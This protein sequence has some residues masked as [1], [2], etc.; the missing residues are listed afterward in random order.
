MI[1]AIP[2]T[3]CGLHTYTYLPGGKRAS[4]TTS[5]VCPT[6][7]NIGPRRSSPRSVPTAIKAY[8]PARFRRA[9]AGLSSA[10]AN[11]TGVPNRSE[12]HTSE[13]QSPDHLVCRLLLEK[14]N[15]DIDHVP[16]N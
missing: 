15:R 5:Y 1:P 8:E 16:I 2:S 12:E 9:P 11:S 14:E 13:L 3:S 10:F 7:V 4:M 6:E